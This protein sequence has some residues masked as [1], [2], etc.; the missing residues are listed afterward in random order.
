MPYFESHG[1]LYIHVPKTGGTNIEKYFSTKI[2]DQAT[3][4]TDQ[5]I[6]SRNMFGQQKWTAGKH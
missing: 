1:V 3:R 5:T 6:C 4:L 2:G